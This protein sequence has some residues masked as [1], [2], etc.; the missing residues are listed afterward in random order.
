MNK[1]WIY[2]V[3]LLVTSFVACSD[4]SSGGGGAG[5]GKV[6]DAVEGT[7]LQVGELFFEPDTAI[8]SEERVD[9]PMVISGTGVSMQD[10]II[11]AAGNE[12]GE[13]QLL[14]DTLWVDMSFG[15]PVDGVVDTTEATP[16]VKIK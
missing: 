8:I 6:E 7:W 16:Y 4:N 12:A 13:Y 11:E 14:R 15:E 10:G 9:I 1:L 5:D 2:L 3:G